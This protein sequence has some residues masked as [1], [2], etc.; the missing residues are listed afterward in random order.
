MVRTAR[1]PLPAFDWHRLIY[2]LQVIQGILN[3]NIHWK[4]DHKQ[5]YA[6]IKLPKTDT[7]KRVSFRKEIMD[8]HR[9]KRYIDQLDYS[10][11]TKRPITD[12]LLSILFL[13]LAYG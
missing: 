8:N 5:N 3:V 11:K 13:S 7:F 4:T 9:G 10:S 1:A 2:Y 12:F 6:P